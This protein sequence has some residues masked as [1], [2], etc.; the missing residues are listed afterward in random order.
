MAYHRTLYVIGLSLALFRLFNKYGPLNTPIY[1][2]LINEYLSNFIFHN[3]FTKQYYLFTFEKCAEMIRSFLLTVLALVISSWLLCYA[4]STK[5]VTVN[6][7][8]YDMCSYSWSFKSQ[9][10]KKNNF[11]LW[12]HNNVVCIVMRTWV[13]IITWIKHLRYLFQFYRIE[14]QWAENRTVWIYLLL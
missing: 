4:P 2:A 14:K 12:F 8:L 11:M 3:I 7:F 10:N 6:L 9:I 1:F 5:I 13:K